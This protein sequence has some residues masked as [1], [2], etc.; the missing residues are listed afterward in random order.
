MFFGRWRWQRRW[1]RGCWPIAAVDA[2][3]T[4][5]CGVVTRHFVEV[6]KEG[7]ERWRTM[8]EPERS[9]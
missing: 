2:E 6:G 7:G 3:H 1:R 8:V 4:I 9:G 5:C